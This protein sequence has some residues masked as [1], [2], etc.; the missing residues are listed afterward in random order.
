MSCGSE[1]EKSIDVRELGTNQGFST[2]WE[3][4]EHQIIQDTNLTS[5]ISQ[6]DRVC[7]LIKGPGICSVVI[8]CGT[9]QSWGLTSQ[10]SSTLVS[11]STLKI[12]GEST[13][14]WKA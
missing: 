3:G 9:D 2:T 12:L 14:S 8:V 13:R 4:Y 6:L 7:F 11:A 10:A 5:A 1:G